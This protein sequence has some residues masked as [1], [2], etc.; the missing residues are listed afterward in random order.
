MSFREKPS[1]I[2]VF[3]YTVTGLLNLTIPQSITVKQLKKLE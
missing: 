1:N 2:A 3:I